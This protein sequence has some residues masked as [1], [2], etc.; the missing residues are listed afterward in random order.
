MR[1]SGL[2]S[3]VLLLDTPLGGRLVVFLNMGCTF[4]LVSFSLGLAEELSVAVVVL[5]VVHLG[6]VLDWVVDRDF[7]MV[8]WVVVVCLVVWWDDGWWLEFLT[9][10]FTFFWLPLDVIDVLF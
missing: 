4:M 3:V 9:V 6:R 10:D 1:D 2:E 5:V 8:D 7:V